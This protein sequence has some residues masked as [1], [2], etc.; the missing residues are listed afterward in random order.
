M[1]NKGITRLLVIGALVYVSAFVNAPFASASQSPAECNSNEFDVSLQK[2]HTIAYDENSPFGA[3]IISYTVSSDNTDGLAPGCD[4][5]DVDIMLTTPDGVVHNLQ[6]GGSYPFPTASAV[7]GVVDYTVNS[8]DK[9]GN[10]VLAS[11]SAIGIL[12]DNPE[13]DDPVNINKQVSTVVISPSTDV[14]ISSSAN[15]VVEGDTVDLTITESNDGFGNLTNVYVEVDNGIGNLVAPPDSGDDGDNVLEPGEIWSWTILNVVINADTVFTATGHGTDSLQNDI[16]YPIDVDEQD[17]VS[18]DTISPSTFISITSSDDVVVEGESV[19]LTIT[20][21]N[22]G[23]T[24]LSNV[25]V[26]LDNGL[27]TL[28]APPDAGDDGDGILEPG[29]T[30]TWT[31]IGVVV[32]STTTFTATGHGTDLLQND[33]T[34]PDDPEEQD[35]V[36][37][38]AV[39]PL[40]VEKTADTSYDRDWDWTI[41]KSADQ[42]ELD[43]EEG[44]TATVNYEVALDATSEDLN[45]SVSGTITITN[46]VGNPDATVESISDVLDVAG[47]ATVNCAVALP[48]V[49]AGGDSLVCTYISASDGTDALNEVTVE[50]SGD[51]PGGSAAADVNWGEPTNITDE[52]VT[53]NDTNVNFPGPDVIVCESDADK[54]IEY[55]VVLGSEGTDADVVLQC[56]ENEHPNVADFVTNDSQETGDDNWSVLANVNCFLGCTLTQGYWKNHS[57][58]GPAPYDENWALLGDFDGDSNEEQEGEL[59]AG[60]TMTWLEVFNTAPKKGNVWLQLAHQWMAAYLNS[61]TG[62]DVPADVQLALDGAETWL[63]NHSPDDNLK[64]AD[65]PEAHEWAELLASYN[66]GTV[67]PGHCTEETEEL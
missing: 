56:G 16:T 17:S 20:E 37:I 46:P 28:V 30:W 13:Q 24:D 15:V 67:G 14:S 41:D 8:A 45:H 2:S 26:D 25:F 38:L 59:L 29:E 33:V 55:S 36:R 35:S 21:T 39:L 19:D 12:H 31:V 5:E 53:V 9:V 58:E 54:T 65:A 52:C 6:T 47:A 11:V 34:F 4:V 57:Q 10:S 50:T 62:A 22:D 7:I 64:A 27:G 3:T 66:E 40:L 49:L 43:L 63:T 42:S 23:D 44:E 51:I 48:A 32:N 18:V 1:K 61:L 60:S